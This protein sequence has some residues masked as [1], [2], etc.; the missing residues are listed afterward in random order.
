LWEKARSHE[1]EI[2]DDIASR[3]T[4]L[5]I[6][7]VTWNKETFSENL[8]RFYGTGLPPNSR[9]E[10][11]CG[12][13]P[14]LAV[15]VEDTHPIYEVRTTTKGDQ[16]VNTKTF[17]AKTLHREWTG[18]GHRVHG[19]NS[20]VEADHNLTMLLGKNSS[21][22]RKEIGLKPNKKIIPLAKELEGANGWRDLRHLFYVL[23]STVP[24]VVLRNFEPFPD[25]FYAKQHGDIDLLVPNFKD[26]CF[27]I[28][29]VPVF[30]AKY[31]VHTTVQIG[32]EAVRFDLRWVG[33]G[34]YD[35]RWEQTILDERILRP[36]GFYTPSEKH[37]F[38]GLLYHALVQK[39]AIAP[40]YG[41]RLID[42]AKIM[43]L[44]IDQSGE[45][46]RQR[47]TELL[48]KYLKHYDYAFTQPRDKSVYVNNETVKLG[49]G[50]GINYKKHSAAPLRNRLKTLKSKAKHYVAKSKR[51]IN[52]N[53][54]KIISSRYGSKR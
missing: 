45:L 10:Q 13:G 9:K 40:D 37:H 21:D 23:N 33:D 26:A 30:K 14:F 34:Y 7:E 27:I 17:E 16:T 25:E 19:S 47:A 36:G 1:K 3:F 15:I 44:S 8:S 38:Y 42:H 31:R 18:G 41:R 51:I 20:V 53:V 54:N 50:F 24:Y 32:G 6:Y 35:A 43:K 5:R 48:A 29:A 12:N 52:R 46:N 49:L 4:I 11:H 22:L 2:L 39:P 28:N